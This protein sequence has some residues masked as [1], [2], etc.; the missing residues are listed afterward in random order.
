MRVG[1]YREAADSNAKAA[2]VDASYIAKYNI[3][4]IY[5]MMYYPHNI[6]FLWSASTMEGR[7]A[8]SLRAAQDLVSKLSPEMVSQ[9]PPLEF[10]PP[11]FLFGLARF[12]KWDDILK[13]PAPPET[14]QYTT[15]IWHYVRGLA[16]T[17][18]GQLDDA[19]KE[20][21]AVVAIATALPPDKV[22]GD[23]TPVPA[24]LKIA[25]QTL[26]GEIAVKKEQTDQAVS[27]LQD[28]VQLQDGLPYTEP[29]PWYYPV[30]HSLGAVLLSAGRATEAEAVYREDL[31]RNPENGW[32]LYGLTQSL[33]T[34]KKTE[35]AAATDK[36]FKK[37]WAR[38]DIKLAASRF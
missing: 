5:S 14:L 10:V 7:S 6:H 38:A 11:T 8:V 24:L 9:M 4:G 18:K 19:S 26:A 2:A 36:R 27:A 21:E 35:E 34:Q 13:Q 25:A 16:L 12:G 33:Q 28:A 29:P 22:I 1:L 23:N 37:A 20:Q 17:A 3:Q 15:A 30:R 31:K 32:A